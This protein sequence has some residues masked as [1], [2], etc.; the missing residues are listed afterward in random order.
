MQP[1][2]YR[3]GKIHTLER[4]SQTG[5]RDVA[6]Q[7]VTVRPFPRMQIRGPIEAIRCHL[8]RNCYRLFPRMQI[9]GPIEA[10]DEK[11]KALEPTRFRGCR[12]AAPLKQD[13]QGCL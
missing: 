13:G 6:A 5:L 1:G 12:S 8:T 4:L 10:H 2:R 9:R 11:L 7:R 3:K